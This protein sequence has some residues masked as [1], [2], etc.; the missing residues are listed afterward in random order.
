MVSAANP[1]TTPAATGQPPARALETPAIARVRMTAATAGTFTGLFILILRIKSFFLS[2]IRCFRIRPSSIRGHQTS[3]RL[4][5][6]NL[7]R[8]S[9]R[10]GI[11]RHLSDGKC[12]FGDFSSIGGSSSSRK[13]RRTQILKPVRERAG[14]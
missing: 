2:R 5:S 13:C 7:A 4:D 10:E 1:P 14:Q 6:G 11:E 12:E 3:I 9:A 8:D